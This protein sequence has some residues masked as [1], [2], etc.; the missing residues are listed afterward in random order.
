MEKAKV[1]VGIDPG[2]K[3]LGIA[4]LSV[5]TDSSLTFVS[6]KTY[7][8]SSYVNL[9]EFISALKKEFLLDYDV[10][11]AHIERYV[12]YAGTFTSE[13]EN[14]NQIIGALSFYLIDAYSCP[15]RLSRV[16]DWKKKLVKELYKSKGFSNPSTSLDKKFSMA[17]AKACV[18][19]S[20]C[21]KITDHEADAICLAFSITL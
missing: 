17:A 11:T 7:N 18:D 6:S 19:L 3:N 5:N 1:I 10:Q 15:I 8:P 2:W 20:S 16:I 14:V 13:S 21:G 12:P 9:N 4:L